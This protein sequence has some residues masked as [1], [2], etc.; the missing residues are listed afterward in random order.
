M[1][2]F[3]LT[4]PSTTPFPGNSSTDFTAELNTPI[5]LEKNYEIALSELSFRNGY[6][7]LYNENDRTFKFVFTEKDIPDYNAIW[8][9]ATEDS[10]VY[11]VIPNHFYTSID[12]II[13][14]INKVLQEEVYK[15]QEKREIRTNPLQIRYDQN[16]HKIHLKIRPGHGH[17]YINFNSILA[18]ILGLKPYI[19]Y[20]ELYNEIDNFINYTP[21]VS[22]LRVF[23]NIIE[24]EIVGDQKMNLL[25]H[26]IT[27][28][29]KI[30][31]Y[32]NKNFIN[33]YYKKIQQRSFNSIRI[34][35][36]DE[37][38]RIPALGNSEIIAVLH[39]K[40]V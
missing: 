7:R 8:E 29:E 25:R 30:G 39:L 2:D 19:W 26:V 33:L 40:P 24:P 17:Q 12:E 27:S 21:H 6:R 10:I 11:L 20:G 32:V 16:S 3:Y 37:E 18:E 15:I 5:Y 14:E 34:W 9:N 35:I 1:K 36:L 22:H 4:I 31:S 23:C 13:L 28:K 38:G